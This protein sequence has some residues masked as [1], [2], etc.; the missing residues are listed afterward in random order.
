MSS[1][2]ANVW[3]RGAPDEPGLPKRSIFRAMA[4]GFFCRCPHCG[5]GS[6]FTGYLRSVQACD[7]CHEDLSHQRADDA[8]PYF[9]ILIV[10]HAVVPIMVAVTLATEFAMWLHFAFWIPLTLLLT[11]A[12]LRPIK[13]AIIGLQ[14]ALYMHGFDP[15]AEDDMVARPPDT[16]AAL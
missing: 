4:R 16:A 14:W 13:G 11:L 10:G 1:P 8:P 2:I 9:T 5:E 3:N 12:L 6:L 15:A 7:R